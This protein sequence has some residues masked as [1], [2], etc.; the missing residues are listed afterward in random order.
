VKPALL[1]QLAQVVVSLVL[2]QQVQQLLAQVV[3][4]V[5][6]RQQVLPVQVLLEQKPLHLPRRLIQDV[7]RLE[8]LYQLQHQLQEEF[9]QLVKEFQYQP[10]Q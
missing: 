8:Q 7:H 5:Q 9:Q 3:E 6:T 10:C 4:L 1:V 2:K